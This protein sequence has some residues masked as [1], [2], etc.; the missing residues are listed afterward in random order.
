M[1]V[2]HHDYKQLRFNAPGYSIMCDLYLY[3]ALH[4]LSISIDTIS[5]SFDI[6]SAILCFGIKTD[7]Y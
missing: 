6:H 2:Y 7:T 4:I 5:S 3:I 1:Y